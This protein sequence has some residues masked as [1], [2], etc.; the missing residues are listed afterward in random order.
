MTTMHHE[1]SWLLESDQYIVDS[2][3][4]RDLPQRVAVMRV[5]RLAV[6][7]G[8]VDMAEIFLPSN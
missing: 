8:Q 4:M 2:V 1:S 3:C 7:Q 5:Q 6:Q